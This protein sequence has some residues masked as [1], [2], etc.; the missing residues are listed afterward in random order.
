MLNGGQEQYVIAIAEA[1]KSVNGEFLQHFFPPLLHPVEMTLGSS[2]LLLMDLLNEAS[3]NCQ[4]MELLRCE[5]GGSAIESVSEIPVQHHGERSLAKATKPNNGKE[6]QLTVNVLLCKPRLELLNGAV[7][8]DGLHGANE[9]R[10]RN[11]AVSWSVVISFATNGATTTCRVLHPV[12]GAPLTDMLRPDLEVADFGG[13]AVAGVERG[14]Q[15]PRPPESRQPAAPAGLAAEAVADVVH[16]VLDIVGNLPHLLHPVLTLLVVAAPFPLQPVEEGLHA[17]QLVVDVLDVILDALDQGV[18]LREE[19]PELVDERFRGIV[20]GSDDEVHGRFPLLSVVRLKVQVNSFLIRFQKQKSSK[21][22][23]NPYLTASLP[24]LR[25][26]SRKIELARSCSLS[27]RTN[28]PATRP[29]G[30]GAGRPHLRH[31]GHLTAAH[32]F[33]I[34]GAPDLKWVAG[35]E[36]AEREGKYSEGSLLVQKGAAE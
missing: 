34:N 35:E 24:P 16:A 27:R 1:S 17:G 15:V 12:P 36:G 23:P 29:P 19:D 30:A 9:L 26:R 6:P 11:R 20:G 22:G 33:S 10:G 13:D 5:H 31:L 25:R 8:A 18:L 32:A 2:S 21:F 7:H 3:Q 14:E 4:E 28:R